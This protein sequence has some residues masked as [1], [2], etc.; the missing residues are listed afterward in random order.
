MIDLFTK[1]ANILIVDDKQSNIDVLEGLL[2]NQ[3][4]TNFKST[5]DSRLV[6]SL[7]ESFKP[8]LILLDLMMPNFN[9]FQVMEQL[10]A[11]IPQ[12]TYLPIL[13]LTASI[14]EKDKQHALSEGAK[15]FLTKPFDLVEVGLRI[16]NLLETRFLHQQLNNQNQILEEKVKERTAELENT[17]VELEIA[18][19]KAQA[20]DRLK[21]AFMNNISHEIRTPLNGILG[22]APFVIQPDISMEEKE[23]FLEILNFSSNRLM[24]TITDYM[25]I[26]LIISDTMEVHPDPIDISSMLTNVCEHYQAVCMKKNLELKT[27]FPDNTDNFILNTDEELLQK[28]VSKLVDNSVKFTK[29]GSITIGFAR[30]DDDIEIFVID[31][32]KGIEKKG[33]EHVYECFMQEDVSST[34]GHEGSGLG[35][36]IAKGIIQLLGG[37][38]RLESAKNMGTTAFLTLPINTPAAS[39][40]PKNST[41]AINVGEMPLILIAEDDDNSYLYIETLL[42]KDNKILRAYNGQEAVDLCRKHPDITL[43]LMDIKM[44]V[45][46][47]Y[48]ATRKIR[49]FNKDV[50]I[51]A[52]TA[53]ALIGDKD[54]AIEAGCNN[55]ISKPIKQTELMELIQTYFRK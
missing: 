27:L 4:Y 1:N 24:N 14:I 7:F 51:I 17:I 8:D 28:A 9:G 18:K 37:K 50:I 36:S 42:R 54:K 39:V 47:G 6:V 25:D 43:V 44:P 5:T 12:N 19:N 46:N 41:N 40:K 16:K 22:F 21:T 45:M 49:E 30:K 32:G 31:T 34:R 55:Y 38:V 23:E 10:G 13:V 52:Q 29:E 20:S 53:F 35:L 2:E 3:G 15:D 11:V 33:Q 48:E 26:S